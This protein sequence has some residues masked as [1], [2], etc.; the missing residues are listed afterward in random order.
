MEAELNSAKSSRQIWEESMLEWIDGRLT[1]RLS[2]I[3]AYFKY[4]TPGQTES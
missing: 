2:Y 3:Y 1:L 4:M